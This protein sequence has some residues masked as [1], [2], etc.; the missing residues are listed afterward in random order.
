[1]SVAPQ[2]SIILLEDIDAAFVNREESPASMYRLNKYS[3]N[4]MIF[5]LFIIV[6]DINPRKIESFLGCLHHLINKALLH[7]KWFG[8]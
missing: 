3:F 2:Q 5:C 1:M 7:K 8:I 4:I 6:S